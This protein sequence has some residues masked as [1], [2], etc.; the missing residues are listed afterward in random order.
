[1]TIIQRPKHLLNPFDPEMAAFIHAKLRSKG[2]R[3]RLGH[4]VEGF[5]QEGD[6]VEVLL[7]DAASVTT[8][9]VILAIGVTPDSHLAVEAGIKTGIKGSIAVN[10]RM[11]TSVP[12]IYAVGDAVEVQHRITGAKSL[13]ALAGPANREGSLRTI[14]AAGTAGIPVP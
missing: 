4:S 8:D 5:R 7:K 2:I 12:D 3:L 13:I 1:M 14:S 10:D 6:N 11:E 9:L